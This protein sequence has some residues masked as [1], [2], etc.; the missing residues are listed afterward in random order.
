[1]PLALNALRFTP[2]SMK[3]EAVNSVERLYSVVVLVLGMVVFSSTVSSITSA[4]NNLKD[5]N[6]PLGSRR[7]ETPK[8]ALER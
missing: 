5:I 7:L 4:T 1:M 2:G 6:A 3:V 8:V